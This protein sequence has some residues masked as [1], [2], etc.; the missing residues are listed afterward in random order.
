MK[1]LF[2]KSMKKKHFFAIICAI[3][4]TNFLFAQPVMQVRSPNDTLVTVRV[5]AGKQV[6]F[7]TYAPNATKVSLQTDMGIEADLI[8]ASSGIWSVKINVPKPGVYRY[9]FIIDGITV[10]DSKN[11]TTKENPPKF[12]VYD[13]TSAFWSIQDVPHG[14]VRLVYYRSTTTASTRRMH[15]YTP[16]GYDKSTESLPVLYLIHGGGETDNHWTNFGEANFILDNLIA[17]G[18]IKPMIVVMPNGSVPDQ[19]FTNDLLK[20]VIPYVES[21][22]RIKT[23]KS[24]RALAGLSMGGI[25][26]LNTGIPNSQMFGYLGVLSS[27]WFPQDLAEKEK[28]VQKYAKELNENVKLFWISMG[29]KED[30]AWENCQNMLKVFDKYGVKYQYSEMPGGHSV[31]VWR[32]DLLHFAPLLFN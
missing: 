27:G 16:F 9:F 12:E 23:G 2:N 3:G 32:Y 18:K 5:N 4:L 24:N 6:T 26:T 19:V 31:Y 30:I 11:A 22:Y 14:D 7:S 1:E 29:G 17:E 8:K 15:I 28:M 10:P 25:E 13:N 21:K 20:D